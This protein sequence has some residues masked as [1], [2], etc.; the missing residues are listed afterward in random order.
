MEN[1]VNKQIDQA[2]S[3][4]RPATPDTRDMDALDGFAK[5]VRDNSPQTKG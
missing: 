1:A 4:P 5:S 2:K 3:G